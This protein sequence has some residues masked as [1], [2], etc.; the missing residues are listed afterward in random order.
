MF[1]RLT[2]IFFILI[3]NIILLGH[4]IIIHHHHD[5]L[6]NNDNVHSELKIE[7][8]HSNEH[9]NSLGE[10]HDIPEHCHLFVTQDFYF[11][12]R[13]QLNSPEL[14]KQLNTNSLFGISSIEFYEPSDKGY[15]NY[16]I[17]LL[18]TSQL[19]KGAFSLRGPPIV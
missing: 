10:E 3:A 18:L 8:A 16:R 9:N 2:A 12:Y 14:V 19:N 5:A 17:P 4:S 13:S 7:H 6:D 15:L 11:K 1:K